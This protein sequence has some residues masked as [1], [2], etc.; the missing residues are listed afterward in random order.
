MDRRR[1]PPEWPRISLEVRARS[2]GRCECEGECGRDHA[3]E[4]LEGGGDWKRTPLQNSPRCSRRNG[5]P[6]GGYR[7]VLTVAHLWRGPC[8]EHHAQAVKCGDPAHLKAMCQRCH[9]TYDLPHHIARA[10]RTRRA[11]KATGDL[12]Q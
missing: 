1:Y 11:R 7:I 4:D 6:I 2:G 12:F 9:L 10:K 5:D 3:A 8:A